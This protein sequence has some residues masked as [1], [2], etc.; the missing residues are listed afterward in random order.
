MHTKKVAEATLIF[1]VKFSSAIQH[2]YGIPT[3]SSI[4]HF[5]SD[6]RLKANFLF[7]WN[8]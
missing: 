4:S 2:V 8:N 5:L 1:E 7:R 3:N 6:R